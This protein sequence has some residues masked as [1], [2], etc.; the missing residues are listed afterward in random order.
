MSFAGEGKS[1]KV[2]LGSIETPQVPPPP[3]PPPPQHTQASPNHQKNMVIIAQ[4]YYCVVYVVSIMIGRYI[5]HNKLIVRFRL[6]PASIFTPPMFRFLSESLTIDKF[7]QY[8]LLFEMYWIPFANALHYKL[9][10]VRQPVNFD[11]QALV[12]QS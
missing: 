5:S 8:S 11:F 1:Q 7:H 12:V 6:P 4:Q 9:S 10:L 3:P 2:C